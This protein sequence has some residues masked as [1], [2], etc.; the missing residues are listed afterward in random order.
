MLSGWSPETIF[1]LIV[2]AFNWVDELGQRVKINAA[3][4]IYRVADRSY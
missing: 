2:F 3:A 1:K 4:S